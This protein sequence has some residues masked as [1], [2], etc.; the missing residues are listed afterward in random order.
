MEELK[1]GCRKRWLWRQRC[2]MVRD[3]KVAQ[4]AADVASAVVQTATEVAE[5]AVGTRKILL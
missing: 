4:T 3:V 5:R 1:E 2:K